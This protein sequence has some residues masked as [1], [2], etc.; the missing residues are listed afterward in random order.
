MAV[1]L[2]IGAT[3]LAEMCLPWHGL[4]GR[5]KPFHNGADARVSGI[6]APIMFT[7]IV[8]VIPLTYGLKLNNVLKIIDN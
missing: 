6:V 2:F 4:P 8:R 7:A 1:T 3:T 5:P